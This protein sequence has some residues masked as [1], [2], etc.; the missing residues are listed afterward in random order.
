MGLTVVRMPMSSSINNTRAMDVTLP[1]VARA[2]CSHVHAECT[3]RTTTT[4][5]QMR[6]RMRSAALRDNSYDSFCAV[7]LHPRD[8]DDGT[9]TKSFHR[10]SHVQRR[11]VRPNVCADRTC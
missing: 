11:I 5:E 6:S 3:I 9:D 7:P 10:R 4:R 1:R 2:E 8:V